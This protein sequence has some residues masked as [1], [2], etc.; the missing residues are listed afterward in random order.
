MC[1]LQSP[2]SG[3]YE[4]LARDEITLTL[5]IKNQTVKVFIDRLKPAHFLADDEST[6]KSARGVTFPN[7]LGISTRCVEGRWVWGQCGD[8]AI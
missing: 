5:K 1:R 4:L 8:L 7:C 2:Y 3:P 6:T